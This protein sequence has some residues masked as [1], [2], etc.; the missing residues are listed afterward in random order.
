[1][2]GIGIISN[3]NAGLNKLSPKFKDRLALILGQDGELVSTG[4]LDDAEAAAR[5]FKK[6]EIDI[7]AI[8]GGDGTAHRTIELMLKVYGDQPV[9]PVLLLPSG[10][11]NMVPKSFG[12]RGSSLSTLLLTIARYKHNVPIRCIKRNI[13]RV[14]G[15]YSFMFGIGSATRFLKLYYDRDATSALGA[16]KLVA[17]VIGDSI[18]GG[19][20]ASNITRN[21]EISYRADEG[22]AVRVS[23]HAFFC[24]FVEKLALGFKLF[25]RAGWDKN[26]FEA[27]WTW[28]TPVSLGKQIPA[29]WLGRID[30][31]KQVGRTM[32]RT[33]Q[34]VLESPESYTLDGELYEPETEFLITAGPELCFVVPGLGL[35]KDKMVRTTRIGPWAMRYML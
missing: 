10:T 11:Q 9:P 20:M 15:H 2:P 8:S 19:E 32:A 28:A 25:P 13:L 26:V 23:A 31:Q 17:E 7:V 16:A 24:S 22:P 3:P 4:T 5:A 35:R 1:V 14:N 18:M 34:L 21:M 6:F 30:R 12:I 27:A 29:L 33:L